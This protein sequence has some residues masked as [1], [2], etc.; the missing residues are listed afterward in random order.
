MSP[1][2]GI[3]SDSELALLQFEGQADLGS[4]TAMLSYPCRPATVARLGYLLERLH[5]GLTQTW[6]E[7]NDMTEIIFRDVSWDGQATELT[8]EDAAP[9]TEAVDVEHSLSY[10]EQAARLDGDGVVSVFCPGPSSAA[11]LQVI[12]ASLESI[13]ADAEIVHIDPAPTGRAA[14]G[15]TFYVRPSQVAA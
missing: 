1:Q 4:V 10:L 6:I 8:G 9:L 13:D 5:P 7:V 2:F 3:Y 14:D 11:T 12:G 15:L